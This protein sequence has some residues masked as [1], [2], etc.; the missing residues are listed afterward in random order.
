VDRGV[1][2]VNM[3]SFFYKFD[4]AILLIM[5][6]LIVITQLPTQVYTQE[7]LP[8]S[9]G[10]NTYKVGRDSIL[11]VKGKFV[12]EMDGVVQIKIR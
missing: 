1:N 11:I 3:K 9:V 7:N 8:P 4:L 5:L 10:Y 6:Y 2:P 12:R